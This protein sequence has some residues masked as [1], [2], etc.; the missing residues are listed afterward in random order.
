M[1][2]YAIGNVSK[3]DLSRNIRE[4]EIFE[5]SPCEKKRTKNEPTD[6]YFY[7][8]IQLAKCMMRSDTL[9]WHDY[10]SYTE[11]NDPSSNFYSMDKGGSKSII[12]HKTLSQ[13]CSTDEDKSKHIIVRETLSQSCSTD[14]DESKRRIVKKLYRRTVPRTRTN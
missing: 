4:F 10:G 6:S 9:N 8:V 3:K 1:A 11:M 5:K 14:E 2:R 12:V 7:L 13:S